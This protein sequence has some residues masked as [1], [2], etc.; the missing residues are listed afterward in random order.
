MGS[1][2]QSAVQGGKFLVLEG[3][4]ISGYFNGIFG[5]HVALD[6]ALCRKD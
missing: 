1:V 5:R 4:M 6:L 2:C 3:E